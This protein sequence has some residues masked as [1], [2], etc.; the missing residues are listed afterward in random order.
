[1][2]YEVD[3]STFEFDLPAD[4]DPRGWQRGGIGD[5]DWETKNSMLL[6]EWLRFHEL[7][8][9]NVLEQC[10]KH[11]VNAAPIGW[12]DKQI[13]QFR[14]LVARHYDGQVYPPNHFVDLYVRR[15][16]EKHGEEAPDL[17]WEKWK[18]VQ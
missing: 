9:E 3:L 7:M 16:R 17:F 5:Q 11:R 1:M 6:A 8:T 13:R 18:Q 15:I 2:N 14:R 4:T 12:R 10:K